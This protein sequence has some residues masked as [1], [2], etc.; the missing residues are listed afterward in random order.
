MS[1]HLDLYWHVSRGYFVQSPLVPSRIALPAFHRQDRR[2]IR[3]HLLDVDPAT[4]GTIAQRD[5]AGYECVIGIGDPAT[6]ESFAEN[7]DAMVW[8][9]ALDAF[10]GILDLYTDE[11]EAALAAAAG[12]PGLDATFYFRVQA[13]GEAIHDR[14]AGLAGCRVLKVIKH[15][16]SGLPTSVTASQ[17][18]DLLEAALAD[19]NS[20]E[21]RR[22][23]NLIYGDVR[24]A[25]GGMIAES[26]AGLSVRPFFD[27]PDFFAQLSVA[28]VGAGAPTYT[29]TPA[30]HSASVVA[31][32]HAGR[33]YLARVAVDITA[34]VAAYTG[35]E[36]KPADAAKFYRGAPTPTVPADNFNR[37]TLTVSSPARTYVLNYAAVSGGIEAASYE[38]D[39]EVDAGATL[40]LL[41]DSVDGLMLGLSQTCVVTSKTVGELP[42]PHVLHRSSVTTAAHTGDTI[43]TTKATV[44]IAPLGRHSQ[45]RL[46]AT[47]SRPAAQVDDA[48]LT[49]RLGGTLLWKQRVGVLR[50][51]SVDVVILSNRNSQSSNLFS[52]DTESDWLV[53]S[54]AINTA[55]ATSLTIGVQLGNAADSITLEAVTL[56]RENP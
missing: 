52:F 44:A 13:G 47:W 37:V 4:R 51:G 34:E 29:A 12:E 6:P 24:R 40:T 23:L 49:A 8:D 15:A 33:R 46:C 31:G 7:N 28:M 9:A 3:L 54:G 50:G 2:A 55:V 48:F 27:A 53:G 21:W 41:I 32:G 42:L 17:F 18:A 19:S 16:T 10:V 22:V 20:I 14:E 56:T 35:G 26:A 39:I 5:L 25:T 38:A 11:M 36:Q 45:L 30:S 43:E 1:T